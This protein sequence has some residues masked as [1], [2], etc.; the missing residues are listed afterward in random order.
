M[1]NC[2]LP[3][4]IN[5]WENWCIPD[6]LKRVFSSKKNDIIFPKDRSE[7]IDLSMGGKDNLCFEIK[8]DIKGIGSVTEANVVRCKNGLAV[9][10]TEAYMRRRDPDCM[11]VS[12]IEKTDKISFKEKY[13]K[14]FDGVR[15]ETLD[16]L[17]DNDLIVLPFMA[18]GFE[19]GYP[20]LLV[21]PKN[22]AFFAAGLADMQGMV[23][24]D[25]LDENFKPKAIIYVAPPFRHT[26]FDKKQIVVHNN[27]EGIH[28]I[29][30]YNLY[31]GPSA[32]KGVYGILLSIGVEEGW[33]TVH[34][35]TVRIT[36]PYDNEVV[37]LH[38]GASGSG[39]SEM[40]EYAH[41]ENDGRLLLGRNVV[42]ND[43][44]YISLNQGCK[45][46]PVTDDMALC[47]PK[48]Q[49]DEGK[50][51]VID[52]E[53]SWFV[54]V[55]HIQSYGTEPNLEM[56]TI[57]AKEPLIFL[58][59][60]GTPDSTCL[61]WEHKEDAPGKR[62]PNPRIIIPRE[63]IKD[64]QNDPMEVDFRSFGIR[65]PICSRE[66]PSYGIFGMLHLLPPALA[67]LWRLVAPRG[68]ANPSIL[69]SDELVSEGVGSYWPF[70][71]GRRVDHA[72]ILLDQ[73]VNTPNTRYILVPNQNVG[74]WEV[75]FMPQWIV[76]EYLARRGQASFK[77]DKLKPSRCVLAG[78]TLHTMQI[79]GT[80]IPEKFIRVNT[81]PEIG[82]EVYDIGANMLYKFFDAEL[83]QI[84]TPDLNPL[85]RKIIE[86]CLDR[87][88]IDDYETF[89]QGKY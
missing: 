36:T 75:G 77:K 88:S 10:Y 80:N 32:K 11:V 26:H 58:N 66:N 30:A 24:V 1:K 89:M 63:C 85:G 20:S 18:G 22:A 43:T 74:V 8:Y 82:N 71:T 54:R 65:T 53:R 46:E 2:D 27:Y 28:E 16:W 67:W 4:T 41:R 51:T 45:L 62:C 13:K 42:T 44:K 3:K 15:K 72:N 79:E 19:F 70:A 35:S 48:I 68:F 57:H 5:I 87:G 86:C 7:L 83:K 56:A 40:L 61:I 60:Q 12:N 84:L 52:A 47:H 78:Y 38:E 31:P 14:T 29:F 59:I 64:I 34:A 17:N 81:Q 73:I 21:T 39:K 50:L 49:S 33:T 25:S 55:N 6:D 9:N 37:F 76:R 69:D 23:D